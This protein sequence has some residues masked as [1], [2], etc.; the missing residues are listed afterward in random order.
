MTSQSSVNSKYYTWSIN[1]ISDKFVYD[2]FP[3]LISIISICGFSNSFFIS[4]ACV[5]SPDLIYNRLSAFSF[6]CCH[7]YLIIIFCL[8][9]SN[10]MILDR[11]T[12][13]MPV[14]FAIPGSFS[15]ASYLYLFCGG[16]SIPYNNISVGCV[17]L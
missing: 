6:N 4:F 12:Q 3:S 10:I 5:T 16:T 1:P 7:Y 8:L 13:L 11:F 9:V 14:F 2:Q 17:K 15:Q